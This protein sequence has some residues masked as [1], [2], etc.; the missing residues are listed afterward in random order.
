VP[1]DDENSLLYL[2][3]YQKFV[4]LPVLRKLFN[5]LA[6]PFNLYILGQDRQVVETHEGP[7]ALHIDEQLI[8]ADYPII[9]YRR[10]RQELIEAARS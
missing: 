10:R 3:F 4:R 7:S 6:M 5:W 1:V 2:R 9:A 8:P